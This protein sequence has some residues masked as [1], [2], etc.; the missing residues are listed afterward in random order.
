[1]PR[2]Q[3]SRLGVYPVK[4]LR[5][6]YPESWPLDRRG[7]R[8][9][10]RYMLVD[11]Q[12][13]F[14]TQ[15]QHPRMALVDVG[16]AA[17][18]LRLS[19]K[20]KQ[21]GVGA[22]A[23]DTLQAIDVPLQQTPAQLRDVEVWGEAQRGF[24]QGDAVA[25]W[26][27]AFLDVSCRLVCHNLD[28]TR[29]VDPDYGRPGDEVSFSDGFPFLLLS[30]ESVADLSRQAG[31]TLAIQR[32]RPNLVVS[33]CQPF[34]EDQWRRIR[35]GQVE[36]ELV[37]PCSR[38]VIP[39]ID[40]ETAERGPEPMR[41]LMATRRRGNKVYLGQNAIQR[42]AGEALTLGDRVEVLERV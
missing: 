30:Q 31:M 24:D 4:S 5:G 29:P 7:L 25:Q 3:L 35:I 37:K 39:T 21:A 6:L 9:D 1:M 41:S 13:R 26:L 38:C 32:F 33:G 22:G 16:L 18:G 17:D 23:A 28:S 42:G 19:V 40:P 10:R 20:G 34:E 15:R 36:F 12:G 27:S 14:I 8:G 11:N 2:I